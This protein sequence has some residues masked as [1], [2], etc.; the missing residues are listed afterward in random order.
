MN[1]GEQFILTYLFIPWSTVLL[2]TLTGSKPVKKFPAFY[3]T[4]RFITAFIGPRHLSLS[5]ASSFHSTLAHLTSWRSTLILSSHLRL[6]LPSGLFLSG[7]LTKTLYA[8]LLSPIH[9]TCPAHLILPDV[10]TRTILGEQAPR[11]VVFSTH[12]LHLLLRPKYSPQ[13]PILKH[14]QPVFLPQC[15]RPSFT[16]IQNNR[17]NYSSVYLNL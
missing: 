13:S 9:A 10:I 4:R 1:K 11:Y 3:G 7:Y 5:W 8:P 14:P 17:Q 15:E 2:E 12:L 16:P 6:D